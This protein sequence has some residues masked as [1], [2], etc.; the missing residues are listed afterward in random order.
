MKTIQ[1]IL[2]CALLFCFA[3]ACFFEEIIYENIQ[4]NNVSFSNDTTDFDTVLV[5]K[6]S[7]T[8][9]VKILNN[10]STGIIIPFIRFN[11]GN[12]SFIK[13]TVN[14]VEGTEFTNIKIFPNDSIL[15]LISFFVPQNVPR[16]SYL[17]QESISI[18]DIVFHPIKA[19]IQNV[20]Y[21]TRVLD[22][23]TFWN[24]N[25]P[26][27]IE[28]TFIIPKNIT[29]TIEA[30]V[31]IF[32]R[33]KANIFVAGTILCNGTP[34]N[35]ITFTSFRQDGDYK[36]LPGQWGTIYILEGSSENIFNHTIIT[37][38]TAGMRVGSPDANN[39]FDVTISHSVIANI[40]SYG[41]LAFSSDVYCYNTLIYNCGKSLVANVSGGFYTYQHCTFISQ[42][43][44]YPFIF[45]DDSL[46]G[47]ERTPLF[48]FMANNI[49]S[50]SKGDSVGFG[51][52][53]RNFIF[54][55]HNN[56]VNISKDIFTLNT[57][58]ISGNIFFSNA[59]SLFVNESGY[60]FRLKKNSLAINMGK[61]LQS[62]IMYDI[63]GNKRDSLPDIGA[64]EWKNL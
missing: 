28:D 31:K 8:K 30:G 36:N 34:K 19:Y 64:Y 38:A 17:F 10:E 40:S 9:R 35:P 37:N 33:N 2:I 7:I 51:V 24:N 6:I 14:G 42:Q 12:H 61:Q 26:Y 56:A 57:E 48:V 27:I 13:L 62:N 21:T 50:G 59:D 22:A 46:S 3:D 16:G 20:H 5:G 32:L 4:K 18:G 1:N 52:T 15:I 58:R 29:L 63:K 49:L 11:K 23:N 25:L 39:T 47:I 44:K 53:S 41:I 54:D 43:D 55:A 45:T 60:D